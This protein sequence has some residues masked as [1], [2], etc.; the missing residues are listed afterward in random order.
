V[1]PISARVGRA[2]RPQSSRLRD[3]RG[4]SFSQ[5]C[6]HFWFRFLCCGF[7]LERDNV[8]HVHARRFAQ[9]PVHFEPV[10][11]FAVWFEHSLK[12]D[13]IEGALDRSHTPRGKF[14]TGVLWQYE[15]CPV[16][17]RALIGPRAGR[18]HRWAEEFR[19]E[20]D[21]GFGHLPGIIH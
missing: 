6:G 8:S 19:F 1:N 5:I 2:I 14:R 15:K 12:M 7:D 21:R 11:S 4:E 13:T 3:G 17:F 18:L 20:T 9:L 10:A 16:G